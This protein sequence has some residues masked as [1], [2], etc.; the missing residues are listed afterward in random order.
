MLPQLADANY[1]D[2]YSGVTPLMLLAE[3][4]DSCADDVHFLVENGAEVHRRS[5]ADESALEVYCRSQRPDLALALIPHFSD[6]RYEDAG[7]TIS[8]LHLARQYNLPELVQP[9]LDLGAV[10][11]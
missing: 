10:D 4:P 6:I 11:D 3:K 7:H 1:A 9:L 5:Y 8:S 2:V